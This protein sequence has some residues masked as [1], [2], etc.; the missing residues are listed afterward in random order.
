M[1]RRFRGTT[2]IAQPKVM[3][4]SALNAGRTLPFMSQH[5]SGA[6]TGT[7][8]DEI[9]QRSTHFNFAL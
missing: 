1:G 9:F 8:S 7:L 5:R 3:P 6:A 4:L 2:Q